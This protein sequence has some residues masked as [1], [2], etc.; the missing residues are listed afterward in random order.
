MTTGPAHD[1][2]P[3]RFDRDITAT[4]LG[5]GRYAVRFDSAWWIVAGPNG[6][7]LASILL[8]AMQQEV[9]DASRTPRSLTVHY[10]SRP[11]GD[12][13]EVQCELLRAGRSLSTVTARLV[14]GE[15]LVAH[16]V[17]AFS[18][19]RESRSFQRVEMPAAIP[20]EEAE[21]MWRPPERGEIAFHGQ[22]DIRWA[23]DTR[24]W[25][26]GDEAVSSAWIRLAEPRAIDAL[27]LATIADALP[28]AVFAVARDGEE[29]GPVPTV[30]L[31]VH[32]RA[33]LAAP[34]VPAG[35]PVLARFTTRVASEGFVEE[36]GEI[37]SADGALLAQSRQLA[38]YG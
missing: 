34:A 36:D 17:A 25:S 33:P 18:R 38:I 7:Y 28:P 32:F 35:E 5:G 37:W 2:P 8:N 9:A 15:R 30:D 19:P 11:K 23:S 16:A 6:G 31:S 13:A 26:G 12:L 29:V 21:P 20:F 4:P 27:L 24:P 1:D 14:E 3:T 22:F 10:T